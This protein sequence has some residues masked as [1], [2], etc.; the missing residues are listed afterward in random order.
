MQNYSVTEYQVCGFS[1][2]TEM[3]FYIGDCVI[4]NKWINNYD[5]FPK[6]L[7]DGLKKHPFSIAE[8]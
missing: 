2:R 3:V 5:K 1:T 7:H 8:D 6:D 4:S